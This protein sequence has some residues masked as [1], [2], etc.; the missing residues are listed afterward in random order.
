MNNI[1]WGED[2]Y[3]WLG[4]DHYRDMLTPAYRKFSDVIGA[5]ATLKLCKALGGMSVNVPKIDGVR[6]I[7]R[8]RELYDRRRAGCTYQQIAKQYGI[9][10]GRAYSIIRK[11][12]A[13]AGRKVDKSATIEGKEQPENA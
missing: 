8:N 11:L 13:E 9:T 6:L 1:R 7:L 10:W 12:E 2:R 3:A 5:E 4:E